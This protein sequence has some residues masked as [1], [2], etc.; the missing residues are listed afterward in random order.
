MSPNQV[1]NLVLLPLLCSIFYVGCKAN[2]ENKT[3]DEE[4]AVV[5]LPVEAQ[6]IQTGD[7][8]AHYNGPVTLETESDAVV[9]AKI[10]GIVEQIAVEEGQIVS[11]GDLLARLEDGRESYRLEEAK[12]TLKQLENDYKRN[13]ELFAK[14]L[15]NAETFE[16]SRYA[17]EAQV[18]THKL[19]KLEYAYTRIT[20]PFDGIVAERSIKLGN[21]IR[22]N[23]PAFRIVNYNSLKAVLH[24]PEIEIQKLQTGQEA[25]LSVDAIPGKKYRGQVD[26]ISPVVDPATGTV[27]ITV[28]INNADGRLKPGMFGRVN[29]THER[30]AGAILLPKEALLSDDNQET[31]FVVRDS[32]AYRSVVRLGLV[33]TIHYEVIQGLE[34]GDWVVT[35]GQQGLRDS[36]QVVI[37]ND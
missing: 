35:T 24:I 37:L 11:A 22:A 28:Y 17:Y 25:D 5:A 6:V 2:A 1:K 33:N 30:H 29:V 26:L 32:V 4:K 27:K 19:A 36:A 9:V 8:A 10:N 21:M 34:A 15:I 7:I 31:V 16:R 12:A 3:E 23:E 13:K 18:A 20:A 14:N